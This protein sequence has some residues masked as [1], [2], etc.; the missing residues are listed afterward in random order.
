[1][2][3]RE[4]AMTDW[5][6]TAT[7]ETPLGPV[8][9]DKHSGH[10]ASGSAEERLHEFVGRL[11]RVRLRWGPDA[12]VMRDRVSEFYRAENHQRERRR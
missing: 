1:M 4:Q 3:Q 9:C 11:S 5:Q 6:C 2:V 12:E 7:L 10:V 8:R